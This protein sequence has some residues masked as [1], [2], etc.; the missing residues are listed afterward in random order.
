VYTSGELSVCLA[1]FYLSSLFHAANPGKQSNQNKTNM[2][3]KHM[4][5]YF[6][7]QI[8]SLFGN[9]NGILE[10]LLLQIKVPVTN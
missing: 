3:C 10:K 4:F 5:V 9:K 1:C 7:I 8:S 6:F 2:M